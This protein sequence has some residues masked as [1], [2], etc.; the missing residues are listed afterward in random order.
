MSQNFTQDKYP[1]LYDSSGYIGNQM[2]DEPGCIAKQPLWQKVKRERD[3]ADGAAGD[4]KAARK[5]FVEK[6]ARDKLMIKDKD[7]IQR[8]EIPPPSTAPS[9]CV[10]V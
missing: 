8:G 10:V 1:E 7:A 6:E 4:K 5:A 9:Y 3:A 2:V